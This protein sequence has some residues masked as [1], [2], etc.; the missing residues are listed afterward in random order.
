MSGGT[1]A[2]ILSIGTAYPKAHLTKALAPFGLSP[3]QPS[4]SEKKRPAL[5]KGLLS[6]ILGYVTVP[7]LGIL[8]DAPANAIDSATVY[9]SWGLYDGGKYYGPNFRFAEYARM[10]SA[11][12]AV[13]QHYLG[14]FGGFLLLTRPGRWLLSKLAPLPGQGPE[15]EASK[16]HYMKYKAVATSDNGKRVM[17][18]LEALGNP[19]YSTAVFV[20]E[21]AMEVLKG[22]GG[23]ALKTGGLVTPATLGM[24]YVDRLE[25]AA[26]KIN[27]TEQ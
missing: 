6:T 24:G 7:D 26:I 19:Y 18:G 2:T 17:A 20:V 1:A 3:V 5:A 11:V 21:A 15:K 14:L 13:I 8:C 12:R 22:D 27:V 4:Q 9:R 16:S 23:L 10:K 25:K